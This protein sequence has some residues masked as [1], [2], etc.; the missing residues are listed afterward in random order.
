MIVLSLLWFWGLNSE[1]SASYVSGLPLHYTPSF[2]FDP[3]REGLANCPV[4]PPTSSLP[5]SAS[6]IAE[7]K[8]IY[9]H[10]Q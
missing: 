3:L 10:V 6:F 5:A 7:I 9:Y 8:D 1:L 4:W 2:S